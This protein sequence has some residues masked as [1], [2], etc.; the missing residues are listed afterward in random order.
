VFRCE[1][2]SRSGSTAINFVLALFVALSVATLPLVAD[3]HSA[4][5]TRYQLMARETLEQLVNINTTDSVGN[6]TVAAEAMAQRLLSAG[7]PEEDVH[8]L[9]PDPRKG[10][11]VARYRGT[12]ER[13]PLLLLA[14]LDVVEAEREDWSFD[15]F[16]KVPGT[17]VL[18]LCSSD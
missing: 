12:G 8:V 5:L 18:M 7:F 15:P 4:S 2:Q 3:D 1:H 11:L 17:G 10:N 16:V 14:H 13:P 9:G 6:T